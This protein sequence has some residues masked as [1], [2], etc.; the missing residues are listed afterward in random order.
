[1]LWAP[2]QSTDDLNAVMIPPGVNNSWQLNATNCGESVVQNPRAISV[3]R[4]AVMTFVGLDQG[5]EPSCLV[6]W[7]AVN[8]GSSDPPPVIVPDAS[9]V[10]WSKTSR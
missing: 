8:V 2:P 10:G 7:G 1:M 3:D 9:K 4:G 5:G 6:N